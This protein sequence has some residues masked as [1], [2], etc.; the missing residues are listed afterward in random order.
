MCFRLY[1]PG[2]STG[3]LVKYSTQDSN[4]VKDLTNNVNNNLNIPKYVARTREIV[5]ISRNVCDS[6]FH[7]GI[8]YE[9]RT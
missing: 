7:N 2:G 6:R 8:P 9:V 5:R 3:N 1:F 4:A